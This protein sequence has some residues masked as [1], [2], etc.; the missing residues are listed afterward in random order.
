M[1]L[2]LVTFPTLTVKPRGAVY[3]LPIKSLCQSSATI[4]SRFQQLLDL[5]VYFMASFWVLRRQRRGSTS[6][7][8]VIT[9]WG[10]TCWGRWG[11]CLFFVAPRR[12]HL[13][14]VSWVF[15]CQH[16]SLYAVSILAWFWHWN[17]LL[18]VVIVVIPRN[19]VGVGVAS[20]GVFSLSWV[21]EQEFVTVVTATLS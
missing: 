14:F 20:G 16:F 7:P 11:H 15:S 2:E 8:F 9:G 21:G 6:P 4:V 13:F 10:I 5:V 19:P 17:A 12:P 3:E 18:I 1:D